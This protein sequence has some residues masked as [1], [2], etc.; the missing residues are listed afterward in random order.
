M[1]NIYHKRKNIICFLIISL[2]TLTLIVT[3]S[4]LFKKIN[5]SN[6]LIEQNNQPIEQSHGSLSVGNNLGGI[7]Y[8]STQIPFLDNF[9]S[10]KKWVTQCLAKE[11]GCSGSWVTNEEE[12]LDLDEYG[13]VKSLPAP[14]DPPEYTR[15]GTL[16]LRE[17]GRYPAGKYVVLYD[18]EGTIEYK[19][20]AKKD[21]AASK[22]GRDV[23]NVTPSNAGIYLIIS[24]TDPKK[25]GNYIR[26]IHVV[27]AESEKIYKSEI[28]NPD[29]IEKIKNFKVVRFMDWM[30]TNN[31]EQS[32]W[33]NRP[34]V[35]KASYSYGGGVPLEIMIKLANK[36]NVEPWFN[37]PHMATD[38]YI[39]NFAKMVKTNLN[40]KLKVYVEYS[41]EVWNRS[42]DQARWVEQQAIAEWQNDSNSNYTKRINWHG[43]RT[44]QMCDIWKGIFGKQSERVICV[45][46]SQA[47]NSW[48]ATE[49]LDC[50]LWKESPCQQ[51][52]IDA[53]AIAPYFGGYL[54]DKKHQRQVQNWTITQLFKEINRGGLVKDSPRG[55]AI[56]EAAKRMKENFKIARERNL[57]LIAYEGGQHLVGH[58]G[59][60][61]NNKIT[62]LFITANRDQRMYDAYLNYLNQWKNS[63]GTLFVNFSDIGRSSKWGSWGVLEHVDQESSPKYDALMDFIEQNQISNSSVE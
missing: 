60:E 1:F 31:S 6:S 50:P 42:F 40:P 34:K 45:L 10:S 61:N 16:I 12:K 39:I 58:G 26:N 8:W 38:K 9:K 46:G 27:K 59:V 52:G 17:I 41:N 14:E 47:A 11:I 3:A 36:L 55:G 53:V 37:M 5:S 13:W 48:T 44:A 28:F 32:E 30:K 62:N 35:K 18:G 15:V 2:V 56:K 51:H 25:T 4:L 54:G 57:P 23:I 19:F 49:A 22:P 24:S 29:F 43:K 20:D 63:G 33:A 7:T 21:E